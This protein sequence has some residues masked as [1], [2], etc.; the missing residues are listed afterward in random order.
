MQRPDSDAVKIIPL[1]NISLVS[2]KI[3]APPIA[4][5]KKVSARAGTPNCLLATAYS[6]IVVIPMPA[7]SPIITVINRNP[8]ITMESKLNI[9]IVMFKIL[10]PVTVSKFF[11]KLPNV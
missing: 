4:V 9:S 6:L 1:V 10:Q 5:A 2:A 11:S 7:L 8:P 3:L